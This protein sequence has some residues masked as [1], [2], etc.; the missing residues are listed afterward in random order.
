MIEEYGSHVV[1]ARQDE[2]PEFLTPEHRCLLAQPVIEGERIRDMARRG[3]VEISRVEI[4]RT[5]ATGLFRRMRRCTV[6]IDFG[7]WMAHGC[8][9][10]GDSWTR[11]VGTGT[12]PAKPKIAE[13]QNI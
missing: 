10:L 5:P 13:W 2:C 3:E 12:N 11:A 6:W 8:L 4:V 9:L 7:L 1:E